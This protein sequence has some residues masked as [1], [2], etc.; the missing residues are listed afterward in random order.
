MLN[1]ETP[2]IE[3]TMAYAYTYNLSPDHRSQI[4]ISS[5]YPKPL[6]LN[7]TVDMQHSNLNSQ[8]Q[9]TCYLLDPQAYISSDRAA[10][11]TLNSPPTTEGWI[12]G[13]TYS[14]EKVPDAEVSLNSL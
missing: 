3:I 4:W 13:F 2:E 9:L 8:Q 14:S 6:A 5:P 10:Y 1:T 11:P 7:P 12:F